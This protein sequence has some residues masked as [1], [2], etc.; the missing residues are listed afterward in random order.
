[1]RRLI[2]GQGEWNPYWNY[3]QASDYW[4]NVWYLH[5]GY[6]FPRSHTGNL[7]HPESGIYTRSAGK[8]MLN[9]GNITDCRFPQNAT[10]AMQRVYHFYCPDNTTTI[11]FCYPRFE[12]INR[13]TA[14][15]EMLLEYGPYEIPQFRHEAP[16]KY[17]VARRKIWPITWLNRGG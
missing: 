9:S 6:I 17:V 11:Q 2:D 16:T 10:Q 5:V 1:V 12:E 13:Y 3:R 4:Q 8:V 7:E 14:S 15:V